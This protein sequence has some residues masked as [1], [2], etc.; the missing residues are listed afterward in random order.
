M[1]LFTKSPEIFF[2]TPDGTLARGPAEVRQ[3]WT[4]FF[5]SPDSIEGEINDIKYLKAG[6]GLGAAGQVTYTR[7]LKGGKPQK[8]IVV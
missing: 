4:R 3:I 1:A 6:D 2:T 8:K 7:Q 5:A